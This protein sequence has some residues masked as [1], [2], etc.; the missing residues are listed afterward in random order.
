MI[1]DIMGGN[2]LKVLEAQRIACLE[3]SSD[4][5]ELLVGAGD[6][7]SMTAY[8]ISRFGKILRHYVVPRAPQSQTLQWHPDGAK[9]LFM[10]GDSNLISIDRQSGDTSAIKLPVVFARL[11][12]RSPA[13]DLILM[14][15]YC[16]ERGVFLCTVLPDGS[17]FQK[18][19]ESA[20]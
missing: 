7:S 10:P 18:L 17:G 3:W 9:L 12:D 8:V 14:L 16:D 4:G 13:S 1:D 6:D 20:Y 5:K 15:Y 2:P 11:L 19:I